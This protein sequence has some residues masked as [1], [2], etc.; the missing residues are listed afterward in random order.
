M[1]S[2]RSA[3]G[4]FVDAEKAKVLRYGELNTVIVRKNFVSKGSCSESLSRVYMLD[5]KISYFP[6]ERFFCAPHFSRE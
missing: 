3:V 1:V 4:E 2:D 5:E 6:G